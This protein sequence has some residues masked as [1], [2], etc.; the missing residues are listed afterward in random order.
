[1]ATLSLKKRAEADAKP[2]SMTPAP[3]F[4]RSKFYVTDIGPHR[5]VYIQGSHVFLHTGTY[6]E[7][8]DTPAVLSPEQERNFNNA[9]L[10]TQL[11]QLARHPAAGAIPQKVIEAQ[12]ENAMA[13]AAEAHSE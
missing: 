9:K 5:T 12:R 10:R 6:L 7:E 8:T 13:L 2:V 3:V 4:D 1:M 11:Q